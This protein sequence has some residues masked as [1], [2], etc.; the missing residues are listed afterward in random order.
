MMRSGKSLTRRL[1]CRLMSSAS[2]KSRWIKFSEVIEENA[3]AAAVCGILLVAGARFGILCSTVSSHNS[4]LVVMAYKL[5][6]IEQK[7]RLSQQKLKDAEW[8]LAMGAVK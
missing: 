6:R 5:E 8:R 1:F 7:L 4:A 3:P 2:P